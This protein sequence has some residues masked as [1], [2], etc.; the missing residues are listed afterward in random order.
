MMKF[1]AEL[2]E[3]IQTIIDTEGLGKK[4]YSAGKVMKVSVQSTAVFD[5]ATPEVS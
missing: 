3:E 1:K 5:S 2:A 4:A